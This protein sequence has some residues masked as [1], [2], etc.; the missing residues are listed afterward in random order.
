[1]KLYLGNMRCHAGALLLQTILHRLNKTA[2]LHSNPP[3]FNS[4]YPPL[5]SNQINLN[6]PIKLSNNTIIDFLV[7]IF[8]CLSL[9]APF[10]MMRHIEY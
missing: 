1:M 6:H 3:Y 8:F 4:C 7:L 2:F 9:S 10:S 5:Q